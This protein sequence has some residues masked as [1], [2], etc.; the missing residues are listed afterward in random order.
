MVVNGLFHAAE[1][2]LATHP[3]LVLPWYLTACMQCLASPDQVDTVDDAPSPG[4][5]HALVLLANRLSPVRSSQGF[6]TR[7]KAP[8]SDAFMHT[9]CPSGQ[10]SLL[11]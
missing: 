5:P 10:K 7:E 9:K 6:G 11:R 8:N 1:R 4:S 3:L 2:N